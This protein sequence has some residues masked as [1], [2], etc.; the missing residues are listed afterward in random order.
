MNW[1]PLVNVTQSH[2][3]SGGIN[4]ASFVWA[5]CLLQLFQLMHARIWALNMHSQ[6]PQPRTIELK[7]L[8]LRA[9]SVH[10]IWSVIIDILMCSLLRVTAYDLCHWAFHKHKKRFEPW[11]KT[12]TI[13][14][15]TTMFK[16]KE[17]IAS[18]ATNNLWIDLK[19]ESSHMAIETKTKP[20]N[21]V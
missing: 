20:A 18:S 3:S 16:H 5:F 17:T 14:I 7:L 12:H 21:Q 6:Q 10:S 9:I 2:T 13:A 4:M 8:W 19:F 11:T 1:F 15:L